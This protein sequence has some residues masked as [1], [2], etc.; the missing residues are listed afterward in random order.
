M[1][2]WLKWIRD[3]LN[4]MSDAQVKQVFDEQERTGTLVSETEDGKRWTQIAQSI[5]PHCQ[6]NTQ[7]LEGPQGG[8]SVNI[9]CKLCGYWFNVTPTIGIAQDIG[10]RDRQVH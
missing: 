7:F 5:C 3:K 1:W 10:F 9:K 8:L 6:Q 4:D 2:N